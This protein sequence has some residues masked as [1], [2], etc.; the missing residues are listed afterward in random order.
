VRCASP[1]VQEFLADFE[2]AE[3]FAPGGSS[4]ASANV[5]ATIDLLNVSA[6]PAPAGCASASPPRSIPTHAAPATAS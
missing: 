5:S 4:D 2:V 3:R 6:R 1:V